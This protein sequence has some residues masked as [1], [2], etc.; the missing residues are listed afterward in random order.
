MILSCSIDWIYIPYIAKDKLKEE[1]DHYLAVLF[2]ITEQVYNQRFDFN[3]WIYF[4]EI[5]KKVERQSR[6]PPLTIGLNEI[7]LESGCFTND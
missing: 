7:I 5:L 6:S 3:K 4:Y 1:I 2:E